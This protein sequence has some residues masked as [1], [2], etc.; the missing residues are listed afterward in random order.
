MS[1]YDKCVLLDCVQW[2]TMPPHT[3]LEWNNI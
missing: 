2:H 3:C 1:Q